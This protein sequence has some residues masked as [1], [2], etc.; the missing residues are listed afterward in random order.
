MGK[1][2]FYIMGVDIWA[3]CVATCFVPQKFHYGMHILNSRRQQRLHI[4]SSYLKY[5]IG[6]F[7]YQI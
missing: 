3:E 5:P 6:E 1:Y 4:Y 7:K 2:Y